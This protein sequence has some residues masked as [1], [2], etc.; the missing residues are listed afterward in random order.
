MARR[1]TR[2]KPAQV[3]DSAAVSMSVR[4]RRAHAPD[5]IKRP[6]RLSSAIEAVIAA[7]AVGVAMPV[8]GQEAS[9]DERVRQTEQQMT[10]DERFSLI[11]SLIGAVP[12]IGQPA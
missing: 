6:A 5:E 12:L 11:I 2:R 9:P 7:L 3:A 4:D 10:D 8:S 1:L